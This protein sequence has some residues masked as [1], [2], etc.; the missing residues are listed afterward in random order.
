MQLL[1]VDFSTELDH[2]AEGHVFLSIAYEESLGHERRIFIEYLRFKE[3]METGPGV[4]RFFKVTTAF[5]V[6]RR[7]IV[8]LILVFVENLEFKEIDSL[9]KEVHVA[10][11]LD[12]KNK[13]SAGSIH[14]P[15]F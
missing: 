13:F 8:N 2:V 15:M 14:F 6:I 10:E 4:L 12:V 5:I 11:V 7:S 9:L 1:A 3:T